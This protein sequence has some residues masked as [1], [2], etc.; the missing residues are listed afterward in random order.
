MRRTERALAD[1]GPVRSV[2]THSFEGGREPSIVSE[3]AEVQAETEPV[4]CDN[5]VACGPDNP[6]EHSGMSM[7][8]RGDDYYMSCAT[9]ESC[10]GSFCVWDA[11]ICM[12]ECGDLDCAIGDTDPNIPFC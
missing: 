1:G 9:L 4:D 7:D 10:G 3:A 12:M 8:E 11:E 2:A 5:L 6:C